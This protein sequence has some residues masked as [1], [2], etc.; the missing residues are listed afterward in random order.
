MPAR[1]DG[2]VEVR[3]EDRDGGHGSESLRIALLSPIQER[4]PPEA[5]GGVESVIALLADGLVDAGHDVTLFAGS[6]SQTK[7]QLSAIVD[8]LPEQPGRRIVA[9]VD[10]AL[11]CFVRAEDFDLANNHM[12]VLGAAVA[13]DTPTPVVHTVSDAVSRTR[14]VWTKAA[15]HAPHAKLISISQRQQE[16]APNLPWIADC[17]NAI[18]LDHFEFQQSADGY[19]VFLGRMS[20]DKGCDVAIEVARRVGIPL[21]IGA[22]LRDEHEQEYF[23]E[24]VRPLLDGEVEFLGEVSQ[25][26]KV[27]LLGHATAALF[28]SEVE[29]GFGLVFAEADGLRHASRRV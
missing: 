28:P 7:A 6:G 3:R 26:E 16:L 12:G 20:P 29:E 1:E 4:V 8:E 10:H 25:K 17:P 19:A 18:D 2:I 9:E 11:A 13:K 14:D 22:K 27:K 5:Y 24:E 23:E 21:K 15:R